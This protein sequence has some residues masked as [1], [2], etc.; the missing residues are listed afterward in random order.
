MCGVLLR[1]G[2]R[3][4]DRLD[5]PI[6]TPTTKASEGHDEDISLNE[7]VSK[8]IISKE[9]LDAISKYSLALFQRG[10]EMAAEKGLILVDTKYEFGLYENKPMLMDEIHT[11]DSSR[12][13]ISHGYDA[14]QEKGERLISMGFQGKED[15]LMPEMPEA[16]VWEISQRYQQLFE[17]ITGVP[18]VKDNNLHIRKRI[19]DNLHDYLI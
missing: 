16:F 10:T 2:Y 6:I 11:P 9:L 5:H 19:E 18:L 4:G 13:Y 8:Q 14:R 15:Q 1:D 12:Y 17:Q 7:I 3:E